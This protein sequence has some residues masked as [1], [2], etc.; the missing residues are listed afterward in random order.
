MLL[1]RKKY[2]QGSMRTEGPSG[3]KDK[4]NKISYYRCWSGGA[5]G[6]LVFK[7]PRN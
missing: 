1:S 4:K 5:G 3:K 2:L 7:A 6:W